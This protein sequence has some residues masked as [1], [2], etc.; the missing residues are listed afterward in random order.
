MTRIRDWLVAAGVLVLGR[1]SR[2]RMPGRDPIL[3]PGPPSPRAELLVVGLFLA[4]ALLALGFV[5]IYALDR[6]DHQTQFLGLELG[7][8]LGLAVAPSV[9]TSPGDGEL[10]SLGDSL[11]PVTDWSSPS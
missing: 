6:L 7:L 8:S 2:P 11:G 3:P 10:D 9:G 4:A 1:R 5:V